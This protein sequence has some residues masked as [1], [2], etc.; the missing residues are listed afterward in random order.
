MVTLTRQLLLT[1]PLSSFGNSVVSADSI[2][3]ALE[4]YQGLISHLQLYLTYRKLKPGPFQAVHS[5]SWFDAECKTAKH[6]LIALPRWYKTLKLDKIP[7]DWFILKKNYKALIRRKKCQAQR[8]T[9]ERLILASEFKDSDPFWRIAAGG[10][11]EYSSKPDC[12]ILPMVW[13]WYFQ[14]IYAMHPESASD[15]FTSYENLPNWPPVSPDEI[16]QTKSDKAPG[17]DYI[18][19]NLL[20]ANLA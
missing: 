2:S 7:P 20:K 6:E 9:W 13:E 5:K 16:C 8:E 10:M 3:A 11:R 19:V 4:A 12:C 15:S 18:P 17:A 14:S 1:E